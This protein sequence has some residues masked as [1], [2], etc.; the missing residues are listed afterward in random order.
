MLLNSFALS[1]VLFG[2]WLTAAAQQPQSPYAPITV[3]CPPSLEIRNASEGLSAAEQSWRELRFAEVLKSLPQYLSS[4]NIPDFNVSAFVSS[5]NSSHVPISGL[6]ISGGGSTSG[7]GGLGIWQAFD[8]RYGPAV[9]AGT[10]GL[11]QCLS[12]FTGLSGGGLNTV[13]PL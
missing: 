12:Y 7:M 11:A 1:A 10:G 3:S 2:G 4:A 9:E 8:S 5:L 6:A 13:L